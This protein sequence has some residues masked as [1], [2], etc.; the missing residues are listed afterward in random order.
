MKIDRSFIKKHLPALKECV[1]NASREIINIYS[2]NNFGE[3]SKSD[4]SPLTIA[5]QKANEV[6]I[7]N[8]KDISPDIP[9]VS[10]ETFDKS[11]LNEIKSLYWLVDP[12]DGT[13][14][15]INKT[16]E[17]TVNIA[18]I[19]DKKAV[20]G[21]VASPVKEKIWHGSIFDDNQREESSP[22]CLRLVISKS[23]KSINDEA[24]LEFLDDRNVKYQIIEKG[25]S[26]KL[27]G[28]ADNNADIYP[29][30]GPTSEWDIAAAHAVLASYGGSVISIP[31]E[32]ELSY[33]KK[34]S[35]LNSYFIAFR[36]NEI[37]SE[38]LPLLRDFF[39]KL[40]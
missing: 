39:K 23:H 12:L 14:E 18:L 7:C 13:R 33:S 38:Y 16:D 17:F 22:D 37:K 25:S 6:I 27:C 9:I 24:F 19:Y 2:S 10:E 20:F 40:V 26:L 32:T 4:G 11:S 5:D 3:I 30:F 1:N 36:N 21:I 34:S 31:D 15:F 8:L 28:L 29:R 35:I